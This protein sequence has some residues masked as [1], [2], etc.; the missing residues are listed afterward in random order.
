M[1]ENQQKKRLDV[2]SLAILK[3]FAANDLFK[4]DDV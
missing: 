3:C 1:L 2:F 4:K